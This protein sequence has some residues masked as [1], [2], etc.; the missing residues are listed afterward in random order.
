L[1]SLT[2][3]SGLGLDCTSIGFATCNP[4]LW[5]G[6]IHSSTVI[7]LFAGLDWPRWNA[8]LYATN[9]FDSHAELSRGVNCGSCT[10]TLIVP[11]RPRTI[12]LRV[13]AKF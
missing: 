5:L 6:K 7:D 4:N 1:R 3:I 2:T 12:G 11:G 13:G 8:E 10:R 9:I